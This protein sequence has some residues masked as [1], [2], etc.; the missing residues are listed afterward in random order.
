MPRKEWRLLARDIAFFITG[1]SDVREANWRADPWLYPADWSFQLDREAEYFEPKDAAGIPVR[2]FPEPIGTR[3]LPSRITGFAL[4]HWN[5]WSATRSD[6]NR[7]PFLRM[8]DWLMQSQRDGRYEHDIEILGMTT[9]WISCI[10]QGEAA[11]VLTRAYRLTGSEEYLEKSRRAVEW[12]LIPE[13]SGGLMSQLPDGSPFLEE[14]P[15]TEYRHVLNGCLY[16]AVGL[17]DH[18]RVTSDARAQDFF[19]RLV[20]GIGRN[21][22][23][24]DYRGWSTYDYPYEP[25]RPRN[26]NSMT[27]QVLQVVLL[28]YL[29]ERAGNDRVREVAERW[30][31]STRHFP[32]RVSA[33]TGKLTFRFASGW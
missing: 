20:D 12:L 11:S 26:L 3:Y 28:R 1:A 22:Q 6:D 31:E 21:L 5:R 8:A 30:A 17:S 27:Y 25:G 13:A 16:A 14:Y 2:A 32:K 33:L 18:V 7:K 29:A 23:A 15:A 24:W 10:A 19:A 4:A 9:P